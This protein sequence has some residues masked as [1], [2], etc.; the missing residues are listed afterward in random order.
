LSFFHF[1]F[2]LSSFVHQKK[3]SYSLYIKFILWSLLIDGKLF[4]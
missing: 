1:S 3:N 4:S 2:F